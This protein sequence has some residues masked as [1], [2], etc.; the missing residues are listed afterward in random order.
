MSVP[1]VS[2]DQGKVQ[3][4]RRL[5][6]SLTP[7]EVRDLDDRKSEQAIQVELELEHERELQEAELGYEDI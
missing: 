3:V 1:R 7:E 5:L 2:Y 4:D 6:R